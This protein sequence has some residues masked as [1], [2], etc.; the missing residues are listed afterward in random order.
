MN[1][2][3]IV[4]TPFVSVNTCQML[5]IPEASVRPHMLWFPI[6]HY[7]HPEQPHIIL[8]KCL[9]GEECSPVL[10]VRADQ[11]PRAGSRELLSHRCS[12]SLAA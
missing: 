4:Q 2:V 12:L 7:G 9:D 10:T 8:Q 3:W 11:L 1:F 6:I 5:S